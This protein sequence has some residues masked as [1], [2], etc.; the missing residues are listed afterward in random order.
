M[1]KILFLF[2]DGV[3]IGEEDAEKNPFFRFG[4]KTFEKVF[5]AV[6]SLKNPVLRN[7]D[8]FVFPLD[9]TLGVAGLPQSGTGQVTIFTGVNAA[10]LVGRHFGPFPYS[11]TIPVLEK[12]NIFLAVKKLG[13]K[14]YFTNAYPK[15]YFDYLRSGKKRLNV[16]SLM[17]LQSGVRILNTS[18]LRAGRALSNEITNF[19]W[20]KK[21]GY[22][23]KIISPETAAKRLLRLALRYDFTLFE[24]Y[25]TDHLGH[26]RLKELF[27]E[28]YLNLDAFL[29]YLL[30]NLPEE[31]TLFLC[32]DHGNFE[33]I[34]IKTHTRNPALGLA[35]GKGAETLANNIKDLTDI[36]INVLNLLK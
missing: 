21:L 31:I 2:L 29:F 17:A 16:T 5:G 30:N 1:Q 20:V 28:I 6:P 32:S 25:L 3:G 15:I 9:A 26:W 7:K 13:L 10:R 4:F 35:A 36:K 34:S 23:L 22:K 14:P 33:D 27:E 8:K 24:F 11:S 12:E 19:R 18:D